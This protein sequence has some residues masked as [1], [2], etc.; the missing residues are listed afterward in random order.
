[1]AIRLMVI[2]MVAITRRPIAP[3]TI[4]AATAQLS[5]AA[6]APTTAAVIARRSMAAI[7]GRVG[8]DPSST[9]ALMNS[10]IGGRQGGRAPRDRVDLRRRPRLQVG[11]RDW[12]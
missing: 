10:L 7:A 1:M 6:I 2:I 11:W 9:L 3:P 12:V 4:T 8:G 5:M